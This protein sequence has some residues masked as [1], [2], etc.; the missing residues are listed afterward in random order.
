MKQKTRLNLEVSPELFRDIQGIADDGHTTMTNVFR[1]AF[2]LYLTCHRAKKG[3]LH[4]G[5][6]SDPTKLDTELVGLI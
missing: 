3:G 1:V 6:V 4:V 2:A 5:I